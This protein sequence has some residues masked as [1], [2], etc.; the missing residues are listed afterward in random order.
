MSDKDIIA[1]DKI[2][3]HEPASPMDEGTKPYATAEE[4]RVLSHI[5]TLYQDATHHE[6]NRLIGSIFT[7]Y[8]AQQT[9]NAPIAA[10]P[11]LGALLGMSDDEALS[12]IKDEVAKSIQ[13]QAPAHIIRTLTKALRAKQKQPAN[14]PNTTDGNPHS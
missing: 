5:L 13:E 10:Q 12:L 8:Q 3:K 1:E 14:Q 2:S 9:N 6:L 4:M 7:E 11:T